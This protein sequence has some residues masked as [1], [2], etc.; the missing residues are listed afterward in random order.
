M[1]Q[2]QQQQLQQPYVSIHDLRFHYPGS[3]NDVLRI[4]TLTV[5]GRGVIALTGPSGAGKSTLVELLAGTLREPYDGSVQVLG[6]E[7][8]TLTRDADRQRHVRRVGFIPQDYGLLPGMTVEDIL[9]QDLTDA[10]VPKAEH[11]QRVAWALDQV[12]LSEFAQR[13]SER[14]SGGQR[15]RVA[16]ARMLARNV[17]LV[18]ADEPTANL[19][20]ELA[21]G[22]VH[23]LRRLAERTPV[24]VVTHDAR[25]AEQCDR[26]IVLQAMASTAL[27]A[28]SPASSTHA[29]PRWVALRFQ[30]PVL[31]AALICALLLGGGGAALAL[32]SALS[33]RS[34]S[35]QTATSMTTT[36]T[37]QTTTVP[38]SQA[39]PTVL[40]ISLAMAAT[41]AVSASGP[42]CSFT[43]FSNP[44]T[45]SDGQGGHLTAVI[46]VCSTTMV[47][48]AGIQLVFF[49]HDATFLGW[50]SNRAAAFIKDL[51]ST[52]PG[53]FSVTYP[54]YAPNDPFCCPSLPSVTIL[55][56]WNG[57]GFSANGT[58]PDTETIPIEQTGGTPAKPF[59]TAVPSPTAPPWV[60]WSQSG[61]NSTGFEFIANDASWTLA[62]SC[63]TEQNPN[64]TLA[65]RALG[66]NGHQIFDSGIQACDGT[67]HSQQIG[68]G[69]SIIVELCEDSDFGAYYP[70]PT[71]GIP[72]GTACT[73]NA[74][75]WTLQAPTAP[76]MSGVGWG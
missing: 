76:T 46:G 18:I 51:S 24:I 14:L 70:T 52:G 7:L 50:D 16:I 13:Q 60:G 58:P 8:K 20:P 11:V 65:V 15:Q 49:W 32:H 36:S 64:G 33:P 54:H 59:T 25:V 30:S 35:P 28:A 2:Q 68:Y 37:H 44:L 34:S 10:E 4:P 29:S 40:E 67:L 55:Y 63:T 31:L 1:S 57:S 75:S 6:T 5:S 12:E 48:D 43:A 21:G 53:V 41:V 71:P 42:N 56:H 19:D 9:R 39:A 61:D 47:G 23:L 26:T 73:V 38:T 62:W 27:E 72:Q 22:T 69:N 3:P 66:D 45:I 17:D 74:V